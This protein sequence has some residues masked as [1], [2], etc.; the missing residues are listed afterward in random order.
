MRPSLPRGG[1]LS[2]YSQIA[3]PLLKLLSFNQTY[4][5]RVLLPHECQSGIV[6]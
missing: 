2:Q 6:P 5:Y 1:V 3:P 4:W